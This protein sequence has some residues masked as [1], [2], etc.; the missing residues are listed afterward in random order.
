MTVDYRSFNGM[1]ARVV[2]A[3]KAATL[4]VSYSLV[5]QRGNVSLEIKQPDGR[6]APIATCTSGTKSGTKSIDMLAGQ[7]CHLI[8]RGEKTGG[9][10]SAKWAFD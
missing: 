6:T 9:S 4:R 2:K 5:S 10:F 8:F 7:K 1:Y 3:K